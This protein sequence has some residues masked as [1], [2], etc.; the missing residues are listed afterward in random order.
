MT[1]NAS[2]RTTEQRFIDT[3][4]DPIPVFGPLLADIF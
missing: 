1:R 2:M 3:I 4:I